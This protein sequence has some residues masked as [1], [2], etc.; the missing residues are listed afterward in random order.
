MYE[1]IINVPKEYIDYLK[2]TYPDT[3]FDDAQIARMAT[4]ALKTYPVLMNKAIWD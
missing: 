4:L 1:L 2:T 3:N